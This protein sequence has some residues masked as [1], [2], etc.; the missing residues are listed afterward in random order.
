MAPYFQRMKLISSSWLR[1]QTI[2]DQTTTVTLSAPRVKNYCKHSTKNQEHIILYTCITTNGKKL[3][4]KIYIILY[5]QLDHRNKM[6][7]KETRAS[8]Y[9]LNPSCTCARLN[10]S[11]R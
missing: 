5:V 10:A 11:S 4:I 6:V 9:L 8:T 1:P 7:S 3:H 2:L